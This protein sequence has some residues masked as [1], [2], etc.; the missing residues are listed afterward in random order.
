MSQRRLIVVDGYNLILRTPQLKPGEG[1]TLRDSREK[2]VNLLSWAYGAAEARFL[3]VFDGAEGVRSDARG[4]RVEVRYA[5]PPEKADDAIR[6]I[7]ERELDQGSRVTVVTSDLEV[8]RHAR[9]M[10]ADVNLADFFLASALDPARAENPEKPVTMSKKEL[11]EW[12]QIFK[13]RAGSAG[14]DEGDA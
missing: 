2:L 11:E 14:A 5:K 9:A 3:V 10:G 12:A 7:V 6:A 8:A 1:R 4:G 13:Q